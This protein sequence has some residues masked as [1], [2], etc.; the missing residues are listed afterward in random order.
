MTATYLNTNNMN[1]EDR[2]KEAAA[3]HSNG[4]N[5]AQAVLMSCADLAGCDKEIAAAV[6]AGLGGGVGGQGEIC[7]AVSAMALAVGMAKGGTNPKNKAA[8]YAKVRDLCAKFKELNGNRLQ[9]RELKA[10]GAPRP[11]SALISDCVEILAA[12]LPEA[13]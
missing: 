7:G 3:L 2:C 10:P 13:N 6:A 8:I 4:Y 9:C 12:E 1:V 11:C 5:C